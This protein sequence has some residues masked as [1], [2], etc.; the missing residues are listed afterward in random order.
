MADK[1]VRVRLSDKSPVA[2]IRTPDGHVITTDHAGVVSREFY[3]AH[4]ERYGLV[5]DKGK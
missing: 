2:R 1:V 5:V 4:R 3:E